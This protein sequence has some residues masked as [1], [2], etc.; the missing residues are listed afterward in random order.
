MRTATRPTPTA[1]TARDGR[2]GYDHLIPQLEQLACSTE[3]SDTRRDLRDHVI[4]ELRPLVRNLSRRFAPGGRGIEDVE[5]AGMLGLVKAVDRYDPAAASG[6]PL[7]FFV[8]SIRG[9]MKRYLRDHSW[10]VRVPRDLKELAVRVQRTA[11]T[12]GQDLGRAPRPSELARELGVGVDE[13][14][15]ALGALDSHRARSLDAPT[16]D[17]SESGDGLPLG[18]QLGGLDP[19]LEMAAHRGEMN[20]LIRELPERERTIL[21]MRFYGDR[22]QSSIAAEMGI[23]QM[24]VSRLLSRTLAGLREALSG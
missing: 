8:P 12:L 23:S 20:A 11:D 22:T 16:G 17:G 4:R 6:G 10:S 13:I 5:Q 24:H 1:G 19:G 3:D 7:G 18:E 2:G 21:M 15:D 14:V 9:E